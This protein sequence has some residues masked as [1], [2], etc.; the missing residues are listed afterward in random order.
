MAS[1]DPE[2]SLSSSDISIHSLLDSI[3]LEVKSSIEL[4]AEQK[5]AIKSLL[6]RRDVVAILPTGFGKSLI[7]Q[8][9]ATVKRKMGTER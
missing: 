8:L 3:L 9:F 5:V 7:F 4:K 6:E 2:V 1:S